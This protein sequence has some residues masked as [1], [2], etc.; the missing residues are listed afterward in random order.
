MRVLFFADNESFGLGER[1]GLLG[2]GCIKRMADYLL[3]IIHKIIKLSH[4]KK[5]IKTL[6]FIQKCYVF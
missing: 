1:V 4:M 3:R 5:R 6:F 2:L